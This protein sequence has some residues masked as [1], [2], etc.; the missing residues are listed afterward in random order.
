MKRLLLCLP[1]LFACTGS[2]SADEQAGS[3]DLQPV[4]SQ[5]QT[6]FLVKLSEF[7]L[8]ENVQIGTTEEETLETIRKQKA[9]PFESIQ[10]T[11]IAGT[12][13]MAQF[14]KRVSV[15]T[16]TTISRDRTIQQTEQISIGSTLQVN[17]ALHEQGVIANINYSTARLSGEGTD[18]SPPDVL[19]NTAHAEQQYKLGEQRLLVARSGTESWIVVVTITALQ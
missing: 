15:V 10:I 12:E 5:T 8:D 11:V 16:G 4:A 19:T 18:A 14:G 17:L 13:S 2:A 1:L 6:Q 3:G 7:R 9:T